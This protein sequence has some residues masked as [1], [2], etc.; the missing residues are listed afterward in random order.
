MSGLIG[1]EKSNLT[2]KEKQ[3]ETLKNMQDDVE[4]ELR[5][6]KRQEEVI[7]NLMKIE[8]NKMKKSQQN[9]LSMSNSKKS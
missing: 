9:N 7:L 6:L 8:E 4:E 1:R 3:Y 2:D 5:K